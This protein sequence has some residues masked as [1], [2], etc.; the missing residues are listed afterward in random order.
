MLHVA[1]LAGI[2]DS[3]ARG[4]HVR[5]PTITVDPCEYT[6]F[7]VILRT[8]HGPYQGH[9]RLDEAAFPF[10]VQRHSITTG[11]EP[12]AIKTSRSCSPFKLMEEIRLA[13]MSNLDEAG[14][15]PIPSGKLGPAITPPCCAFAVAAVGAASCTAS[16]RAAH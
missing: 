5:R 3:R 4:V 1:Q 2:V 13:R 10:T 6:P 8:E 16:A 14:F 7:T 15:R 9:P 11:C 12:Y